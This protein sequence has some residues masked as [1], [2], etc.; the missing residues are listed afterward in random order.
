MGR[1]SHLNGTCG[2]E[3]LHVNGNCH[4]PHP[5]H[6]KNV[7]NSA[8][9]SPDLTSPHSLNSTRLSNGCSSSSGSHSPHSNGHVKD[10][11]SSS[12]YVLSS[13]NF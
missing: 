9:G 3:T 13:S 5:L 12:G 7:D 10:S 4:P 1:S 2:G 8:P 6:R 11:G